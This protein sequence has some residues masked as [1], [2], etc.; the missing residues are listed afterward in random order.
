M[1]HE[2]SLLSRLGRHAEAGALLAELRQ[3]S[4]ERFVPPYDLALAYAGVGDADAAL[5]ELERAFEARDP[6]MVLLRVGGWD[7]VRER[8][9]FSDLLRRL[10][11]L[12]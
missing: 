12:E 10:D 2:V 5:A 6:K 3:H 4:S 11:L 7:S 1:A 8:P 9:E